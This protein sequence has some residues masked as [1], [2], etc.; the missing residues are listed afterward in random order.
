MSPVRETKPKAPPQPEPQTAPNKAPPA[1]RWATPGMVRWRTLFDDEVTFMRWSSLAGLLVS[2][3]PHLHNVTSRGQDRWSFMGGEGHRVYEVNGEELVWSP[4]FETITHLLRW[5]RTGWKR[6]WS[7]ELAEDKRGGFLLIDAATAA[8][9]GP[10]GK[11]RWRAPIEGLR[12][13]EGPFPCEGGNLFHGVR[14]LEGIAVNISRRGAVV[15]ETALERGS[16]IL[17][18]SPGCD[19]L[20][21]NGKELGPM[22]ARGLYEWRHASSSS[23]MIATTRDG[24]LL[25]N[26]DPKRPVKVEAIA[27]DGSTRWR[28][29]L[30]VSGR[31]TDFET[32]GPGMDPDFVAMCMDVSSPCSRPN[33]DRGPFNAILSRAATGKYTILERHVQGHAGIA[34][35][36]EGGVFIASS[37]KEN[38]TVVASRSPDGAV[39]WERALAGRLTAGPYVGPDGEVYVAT[40]AGW[41]CATPF[42]LYSMTGVP[43][44]KDED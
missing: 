11:D 30:P 21:W 41:T 12:K 33:G 8:A 1:I 26:A 35:N 22:D 14:G 16:I 7:A 36:P 9:I 42:A 17:G 29:D 10:D 31:V 28:A 15:R 24:Y 19:P 5:G 23:P 44:K 18:S 32:Y 20:V 25:L 39:R 43:P 37:S 3:G 34:P 40:C 13:L 38:E 6:K 2:V 4:R 27:L